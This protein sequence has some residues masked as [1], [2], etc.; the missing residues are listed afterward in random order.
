MFLSCVAFF[1]IGARARQRKWVLCG[2]LYLVLCFV[3]PM[4]AAEVFSYD[5]TPYNLLLTVF[6]LAWLASIIH[7]FISRKE[8]LMR[9]EAIVE[10]QEVAAAAY[11]QQLQG[12]YAK[13]G[14]IQQPIQPLMP[15]PSA[16]PPAPEQQAA[17]PV[18]KIDLNTASE[19]QLAALPGVGVALAKKA[20]SM[21]T[22]LGGYKSPQDFCERLELMPHFAIQIEELAFA[23]PPE[24][25][26]PVLENK[27]RVIDI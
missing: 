18:Q 11:R 21:R 8:Y 26:A 16:L 19:Q 6:V 13:Q 3:V 7:A 17:P 1:W 4:T 15:Q 14:N 23:T 9:R 24:E 27:G 12:E 22:L 10:Q 20:I 5:E 25:P 2:C